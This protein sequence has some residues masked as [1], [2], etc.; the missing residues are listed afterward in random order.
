MKLIILDDI[1]KKPSQYVKNI[2]K[3]G[4]VDVEDGDNVFKGIQVRNNDELEKIVLML[5]PDYQVKYNFVR[6]SP[7]QQEEPNYIHSDEMMGDK[8]ILLYLNKT[9]PENAGTTF[10]NEDETKSCDVRMKYNRLVAFDSYHKHS[11]TLYDNF[12]KGDE[13]RLVQVMFLK[14]TGREGVY[15]KK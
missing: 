5:F 6:Q 13:S 14:S 10:Y 3:G 9:F 1:I 12:G 15:Y 7:F 2:L 8:T 11:R 4:F